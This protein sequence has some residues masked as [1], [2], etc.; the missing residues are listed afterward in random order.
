M[1]SKS[2]IR[3]GGEDLAYCS[4]C[5]KEVTGAFCSNC[6]QP[7]GNQRTEYTNTYQGNYQY[8]AYRKTPTQ[9]LADREKAS[10]IVW[11]VIASL[12]ALL[13]LFTFGALNWIGSIIGF[14]L[15]WG[16]IFQIGVAAWNGYGA[17]CSFQRVKRVL[18]RQRGIVQE[19]DRLLT[20][21][22]VF[23]VVNALF[24]AVIGIAGAVFD[25]FNRHYALTNAQYLE[26]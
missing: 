23:I 26:D 8:Q 20:G 21:S 10:A 4:N 25:L 2:F 24:G 6:G 13:A 12:Q 17:Y 18:A 14:N 16:S 7:T 11:T 22:I 19:Y 3:Q 5:G 9:T 15:G 1:L